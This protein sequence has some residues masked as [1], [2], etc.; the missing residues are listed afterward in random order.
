M[1]ATKLSAPL[2]Y[3]EERPLRG[4]IEKEVPPR[5]SDNGRKAAESA[6]VVQ[7][8]NVFEPVSP[9]SSALV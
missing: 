2:N 3:L 1:G 6:Y 4:R 8:R 9:S 7:A 5:A